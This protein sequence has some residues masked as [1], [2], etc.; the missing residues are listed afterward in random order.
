M[1]TILLP[2]DFG[3]H[4]EKAMDFAIQIARKADAKII[5]THSFYIP[6]MDVNIPANMLREVYDEEKEN[7]EKELIKYSRQISSNI[8]ESGEPLKAEYIAEQNFATDE[9]LKLVR[10]KKVDM[11][12]MGTGGEDHLFGILG[13]TT[14]EVLN[15]VNCPV[16]VVHAES[17]FRD[18]EKIYFALENTKED[19]LRIKHLIPLARLFRSKISLLHIERFPEEINELRDRWENK[20]D[21]EILLSGIREEYNFPDI[22]FRYEISDNTFEKIDAVLEDQKPD[23]MV[24]V[25]QERNWFEKFFHKSVIR[26][27]VRS[28]DTPLL[29]IH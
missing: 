15:K 17:R 13:S 12:I 26:Y 9:I 8:S 22:K 19:L 24:L 28:T 7:T 4:S 29:V 18:F 1:K 5:V 23:L 20:E 25:R 16:L 2:T 10:E 21:S 3:K 6:T 27:L 14:L 11:V